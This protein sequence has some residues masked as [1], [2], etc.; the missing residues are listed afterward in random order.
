MQKALNWIFA[1][2]L[3]AG[4]AA[5]S[6]YYFG[7]RRGAFAGFA[8]ATEKAAAV[9]HAKWDE[10]KY[11]DISYE[12]STATGASGHI[13][14]ESFRPQT[15]FVGATKDDFEKVVKYYAEKVGPE[16]SQ[17]EFSGGPETGLHG[18]VKSSRHVDDS[19]RPFDGNQQVERP[20]KLKTFA[21]QSKDFNLTVTISKSTGEDETHLII[22]H[23]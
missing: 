1:I 12:F 3:I 13:G 16:Q 21:L 10:W 19:V 9:K 5:A 2:I 22:V 17:T 20:V 18:W 14:G 11:P 4:I 6:G 7:F 23:Q 8:Q 15:C